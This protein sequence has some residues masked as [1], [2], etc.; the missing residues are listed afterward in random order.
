MNLKVGEKLASTVCGSRFVVV[1]AP[2]PWTHT[3]QG[4][5]GP[6]WRST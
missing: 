1:A 4:R 2:K 6:G 5:G 3:S